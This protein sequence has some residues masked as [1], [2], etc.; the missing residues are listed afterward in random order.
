VDRSIIGPPR[1]PA[2]AKI[3]IGK[4]FRLAQVLREAHRLA[5]RGGAGK[6]MWN[7]RQRALKLEANKV[8]FIP[9][10]RSS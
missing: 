2:A 6:G 9:L 3:R 5:E 1:E 10:R 7:A 4:R 8:G